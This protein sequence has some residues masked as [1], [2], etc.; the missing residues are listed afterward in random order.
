[1][2]AKGDILVVDDT[3]ESLQ[4]LTRILTAEGYHARPAD[5]GELALASVAA[6][7]PDLILLDIRMPGMDGFEVCRRLKEDFRSRH[8]PVMF[9]SALTEVEERIEGLRLGAV[10][11]ISKPFRKEELLL[12]IGSHLELSRLRMGLEQR[13]GER[14]VELA[15]ANQRLQVELAERARAEEALRESELR[16]RNMADTAPVAI[17]TSGPDSRINFCNQ[18]AVTFTGRK[19]EELTGGGWNEAVHPED[20]ERHNAKYAPL[21]EAHHEYHAEYR[22]R[23]ADG[24]YRWMLDTATPRFF[25]DGAFAGYIGVAMDV[26]DLK[27]NQEQLLAAQKRESL[28]VL[29]A[30]VAHTFNNQIGT[31]LAEADLALSELP[32]TSPA[33]GNVEQINRVAMRAAGIIQLLMAYAGTGS[34]GSFTPVSLSQIVEET[35]RLF[36]ATVSKNVVFHLDL[37]RS[38]PS[39]RADISNTRQA[40]LNL[41][42]NAWESLEGKEGSIV[43]AT[44]LANIGPAES[45]GEWSGLNPGSYVR[46]EVTDN[47]CGIPEADRIRIFDPFYTTKALGRGLGLAAVQGIVSAVGGGLRIRSAPGQG[48]TF[49]ILW[50]ATQKTERETEL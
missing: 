5:S 12:R 31:V 40:V 42:V 34:N 23:R 45:A 35:A 43:V 30:G 47:G 18:Y 36:R 6:S 16:F 48:S 8:I 26:G 20:L 27:R 50:P 14:T 29:V 39:I 15:A 9:A 22:L 38:L 4:T 3:V 28:G 49:E 32:S 2:I 24:V 1:M 46:L 37:A 21:I 11:F 25:A 13:V 17:W 19:M 33:Y 10:D 44:S 7:L 41:L